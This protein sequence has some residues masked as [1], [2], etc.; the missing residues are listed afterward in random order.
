MKGEVGESKIRQG[1]V[2]EWVH[3]REKSEGRGTIFLKAIE[4]GLCFKK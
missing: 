3:V 4:E 2:S 1:N